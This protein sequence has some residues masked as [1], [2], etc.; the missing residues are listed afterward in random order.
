MNTR[1]DFLRMTGV[2]ALAIGFRWPEPHDV[3]ETAFK[4]NAWISI[5]PDGRILF[6][7]GKTEMGQGVRTSLPMILADEIG[8]D[9]TKVDLVQ[10]SPGKDFTQLG[11]GGSWSVGGSW[12]TLRTAGA[13]AREMLI[14]AAAARWSVDPAE[15]NRERSRAA[16]YPSGCGHGSP[17]AAARRARAREKTRRADASAGKTAV[18]RSAQESGDRVRRFEDG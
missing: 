3:E 8:A 4:P 1:R 7:V 17:P 12:K 2:A 13:A 9:L 5:Q 18:P 14:A 16:L 6:T 10:A 11:T 15:E